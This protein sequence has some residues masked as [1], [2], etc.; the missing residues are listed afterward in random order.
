MS[1]PIPL[2]LEEAREQIP[3]PHALLIEHL[4]SKFG[5]LVMEIGNGLDGAIDTANAHAKASGERRVIE[6]L[7]ALLRKD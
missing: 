7:A 4:E 5:T 6:Y 2:T 3:L 1:L